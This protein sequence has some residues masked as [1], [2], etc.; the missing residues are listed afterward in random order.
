MQVD[1]KLVPWNPKDQF[2]D[3][4]LLLLMPAKSPH[5]PAGHF[6]TPRPHKEPPA[7]EDLAEFKPV[8]PH[9]RP[10]AQKDPAELKPVLQH[11]KPPAPENP[12]ELKPVLPHD[13][14]PAPEDLA[15]LNP[16]LPHDKPP[17]LENPAELKPVLPHVKPPA[18][19]DS[20]E[21]QV[22]DKYRHHGNLFTTDP[23]AVSWSHSSE[24]EQTPAADDPHFADALLSGTAPIILII[25][26]L[27]CIIRQAT[28]SVPVASTPRCVTITPPT[29]CAIFQNCLI[30]F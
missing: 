25:L 5:G 27:A 2:A 13:K 15:E 8:L 23:D 22:L 30:L 6:S 3:D 11:D 28:R 7:Q 10:P 29:T 18:R 20:A 17:A 24:I 21:R 12:A 19:E 1:G 16:V 9:N 4:G 14:L 26:A